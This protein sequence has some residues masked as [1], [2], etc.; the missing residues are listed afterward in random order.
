MKWVSLECCALQGNGNSLFVRPLRG[1]TGNNTPGRAPGLVKAAAQ[2]CFL[3]PL[4]AHAASRGHIFLAAPLPEPPP[5]ASD[6]RKLPN[7][8]GEG[9]LV[10]RRHGQVRAA[11]PSLGPYVPYSALAGL[12]RDIKVCS[13]PSAPCAPASALRPRPPRRGAAGCGPPLLRGCA[14]RLRSAP[15][16][17]AG[18]AGSR[19]RPLGLGC[20]RL[21]SPVAAP[22]PRPPARLATPSGR[23]G[24]LRHSVLRFALGLLRVGLTARPPRLCGLASG[25]SA[26]KPRRVPPRAAPARHGW[27][28][29]PLPPPCRQGWRASLLPPG[30]WSGPEGRFLRPPAPGDGGKIQR[31]MQRG[32]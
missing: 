18:M 3:V 21:R 8:H 7:P 16:S 9:P 4:T 10:E 15:A 27:S 28:V 31:G 20:R 14:C 2:D 22:P 32:S 12:R 17:P 11:A 26:P 19:P 30:A 6:F 13:R 29:G 24:R 23:L 25:P 1:R 5:P